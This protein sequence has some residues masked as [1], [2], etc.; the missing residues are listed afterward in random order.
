MK[1]ILSL[2]A[3]VAIAFAFAA[4]KKTESTDRIA[5]TGGSEWELTSEA[6][7]VINNEPVSEPTV[8]SEPEI[9]HVS[10]IKLSAY[11]RTLTEGERFM[12]I[13]T[14]SPQNATNKAEKW[15]TSDAA[16]AIVNNYGN[17][18]AKKEGSCTVTVTSVDNPEIKAEFK[19]TVKAPEKI[20]LTYRDGI[21]IVNKT[22]PLP[23]NYNPGVNSEAQAALNKMFAAAKAEK[24]SK[25]GYAQALGATLFRK[26]FITAM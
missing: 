13:V 7:P 6:V 3:A 20:E 26:T 12:P 8:S 24:I 16:I 23:S 25:C 1:R 21:L 15:E 22:Y 9:I 17:I 18:T 5:S 2:T 19:V 14:M 10:G 4:C 11:E